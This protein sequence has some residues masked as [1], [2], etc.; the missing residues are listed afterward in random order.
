[1]HLAKD[2][3]RMWEEKVC[4]WVPSSYFSLRGGAVQGPLDALPHSA[5]IR[6][7]CPKESALKG[8]ASK[9]C[10]VLAINVVMS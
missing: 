4:V 3:R 8:N 10:L 1:M 5:W 6:T 2:Q 9:S 7:L